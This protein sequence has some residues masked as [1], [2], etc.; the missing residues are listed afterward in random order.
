MKRGR[1]MAVLRTDLNARKVPSKPKKKAWFKSLHEWDDNIDE[2][3]DNNMGDER[4]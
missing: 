1:E 3:N 4:Q 2:E